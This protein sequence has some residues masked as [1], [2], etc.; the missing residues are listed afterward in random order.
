MKE[1]YIIME[2]Y[3]DGEGYLHHGIF[4]DTGFFTSEESAERARKNILAVYENDYYEGHI[5]G[6]EIP[7]LYV[8]K[9]TKE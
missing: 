1:I 2:R 8:R 4:K 5:C 7:T 3:E 9:L 6:Y